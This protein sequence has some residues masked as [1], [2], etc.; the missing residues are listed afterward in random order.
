MN[1]AAK[2]P[3]VGKDGF[4]QSSSLFFGLF[5]WFSGLSDHVTKWNDAWDG[6]SRTSA[7]RPW[8][9]GTAA[10][11][12]TRRRRAPWGGPPGAAAPPVWFGLGGGPA[13]ISVGAA[14]S[15]RVYSHE[16]KRTWLI[17]EELSGL[18]MLNDLARW[19]SSNRIKPSN[20][21]PPRNSTKSST[22]LTF[23][24]ELPLPMCAVRLAM[25]PL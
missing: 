22:R 6:W 19:A 1:L 23:V 3:D 24:A 15:V 7:R 2:S 20:S 18:S 14:R 5:V 9:R 21:A 4:P 13:W 11:W 25:R 16:R 17:W 10:P 12:R 8:T